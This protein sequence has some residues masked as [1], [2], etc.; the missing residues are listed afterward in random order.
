VNRIS[1]VEA[2]WAADQF[3]FTLHEIRNLSLC[4]YALVPFFLTSLNSPS[5]MPKRKSDFWRFFNEDLDL[6]YA[7]ALKVHA[8]GAQFVVL[9]GIAGLGSVNRY[10]TDLW[11]GVGLILMGDYTFNDLSSVVRFA[12]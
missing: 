7:L 12:G 1:P 9:T 5:I 8:G 2:D 4:T 6:R 11:S 3:R 10:R